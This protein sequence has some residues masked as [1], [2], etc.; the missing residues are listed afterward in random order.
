MYHIQ[1]VS[2]QHR[3]LLVDL[4][5]A[6][7]LPVQDLPQQLPHFFIAV[8]NGTVI[9]GIGLEAHGNFGLLRSLVVDK[10]WRNQHIADKLV[11]RLQEEA[12]QLDLQALYLLTETAAHYFEKKGFVTVSRTEVPAA[13]LQSSEF[14]NVCPVSATVMKKS[15]S[16]SLN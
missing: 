13:L 6:E 10:A 11:Q 15:I 7:K 14:S 4:L 16:S 3:Q 9:G 2:R 5:L 1:R 8:N 12:R